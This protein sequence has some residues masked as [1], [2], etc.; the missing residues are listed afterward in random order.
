MA[1]FDSDIKAALHPQCCKPGV[2]GPEAALV[3]L[4]LTIFTPSAPNPYLT[5]LC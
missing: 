4:I 5:Q 1:P 3:P 2:V